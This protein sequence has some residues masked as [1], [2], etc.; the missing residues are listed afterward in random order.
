MSQSKINSSLIIGIIVGM[1]AGFG[2]YY[3]VNQ[4][5]MNE[6]TEALK[7]KESEYIVASQTI[8]TL[9]NNI[10]NLNNNLTK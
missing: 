6:L 7:M 10:S 5:K 3:I 9:M 4:P 2:G 8:V 1:I